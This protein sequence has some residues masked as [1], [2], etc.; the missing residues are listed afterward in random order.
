VWRCANRSGIYKNIIDRMSIGRYLTHLLDEPTQFR[1][2][3]THRRL[4][5]EQKKPV[6]RAARMVLTDGGI[7]M[8]S[9]HQSTNNHP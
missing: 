2:G 7:G 3:L 9:S 5:C 1:Q 8:G 4:R 6:F